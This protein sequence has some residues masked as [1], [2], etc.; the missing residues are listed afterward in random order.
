MLIIIWLVGRISMTSIKTYQMFTPN[1]A[2]IKPCNWNYWLSQARFTKVY[3]TRQLPFH[4]RPFYYWLFQFTHFYWKALY[5]IFF[6]TNYMI[7]LLQLCFEWHLRL[8]I[9]TIERARIGRLSKKGTFYEKCTLECLL[10]SAAKNICN[11][12]TQ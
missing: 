8:I 3:F 6:G 2:S 4:K 5:S 11:H 1:V 7:L 10:Y 12:G 9:M